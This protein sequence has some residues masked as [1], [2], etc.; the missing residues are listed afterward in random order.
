MPYLLVQEHLNPATGYEAGRDPT[1]RQ[2]LRVVPG[3]AEA[4]R[5]PIA[6]VWFVRVH[7]DESD[8]LKRE[9][10]FSARCERGWVDEVALF[11]GNLLEAAQ[12]RI[13]RV[14]FRPEGEDLGVPILPTDPLEVHYTRTRKGEAICPLPVGSAALPRHA[15]RRRRPARLDAG[16]RGGVR[17]PL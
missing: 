16:G 2:L 13:A 7:W 3:S 6:D 17:R 15:P 14:T 9:F 12:G 8:Q 1:R 11:H 10:C 5:D 4:M